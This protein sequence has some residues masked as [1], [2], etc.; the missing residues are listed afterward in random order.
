MEWPQFLGRTIDP[1]S[2]HAIWVL[3]ER[4]FY[5]RL[6]QA[7]GHIDLRETSSYKLGK[8]MYEILFQLATLFEV[9][10]NEHLDLF[11]NSLDRTELFFSPMGLTLLVDFVKNAVEWEKIGFKWDDFSSLNPENT[12]LRT[13]FLKNR[14]IYNI[15]AFYQQEVAPFIN[16]FTGDAIRDYL[17]YVLFNKKDHDLSPEA[18]NSLINGLSPAVLAKF[19]FRRNNKEESLHLYCLTKPA[20]PILD[21]S[22]K[23]LLEQ[24]ASHEFC[25][26]DRSWSEV[27]LPS[28]L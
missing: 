1:S 20:I 21:Y 4:E 26:Q 16:Y 18:I 11:L 25:A 22:S 2:C 19:R 27:R 24:L 6:Q 17:K 15:Q 12:Y 9:G 3:S 5:L 13:L 10:T 23:E 8:V 28:Q 7:F 14:E